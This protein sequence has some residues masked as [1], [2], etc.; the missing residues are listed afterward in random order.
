MTNKE[1]FL[2]EHNK[3]SPLSLQADLALLTQFKQ[4]KQSLFKNDNWSID[5][6][7]R[8]FII[9][10]TALPLSQKKNNSSS[11][12]ASVVGSTKLVYGQTKSARQGKKM[13]KDT[14]L[15]NTYPYDEV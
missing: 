7:R 2:I 12:T 15:F 6:L 11:P 1:K 13:T 5:K 14:H 9:W 3:L 10:L 8:P 4:E